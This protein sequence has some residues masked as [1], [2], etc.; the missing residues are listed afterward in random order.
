MTRLLP[1]LWDAAAYYAYCDEVGIPHDDDASAAFL[2]T[3]RAALL[4]LDAVRG[5]PEDRVSI[6]RVGA[7]VPDKESL[8]LLRFVVLQCGSKRVRYKL[9]RSTGRL[10][11]A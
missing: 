4:D 5:V 2:P 9:R 11:P 6:H 1:S 3:W 10:Q 8:D 7:E